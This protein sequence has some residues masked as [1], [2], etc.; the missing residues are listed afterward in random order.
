MA[1]ISSSVRASQRITHCPTARSALVV[2]A[3][4]GEVIADEE[5]INDELDLLG[6]QID[7]AAPPAFEIE[8]TIG[9]GVDLGKDIVLLRPQRVRG[10]LAL[11]ILHEPGAVELAAAEVARQCG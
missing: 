6:I 9:F 5:F 2:S 7:M 1:R 11:E 4:G 8:I 10:V 3:P